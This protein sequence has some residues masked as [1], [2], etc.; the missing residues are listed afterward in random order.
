MGAYVNGVL[1][2]PV[3]AAS[4]DGVTANLGTPGAPQDGY[5]VTYEVNIND[6]VLVPMTVTAAR[7][8]DA[9][10]TG[11]DLVTATTPAEGRTV[12]SVSE[13][14]RLTE[15]FTVTD[16]TIVNATSPDKGSSAATFETGG[17]GRITLGTTGAAVGLT[18]PRIERALPAWD[19]NARWHFLVKLHARLNTSGYCNIDLYLRDS[20]G[21]A[22]RTI[23]VTATASP[24]DIYLTGNGGISVVGPAG[25]VAWDGASVIEIR[26]D[27]GKLSYGAVSGAGIF[28]PV[29]P[30]AAEALTFVPSHV[31]IT[32]QVGVA[33]AGYVE[34]IDP[35]IEVMQ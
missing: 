27:A 31:G 14:T 25:A 29:T 30:G 12:L 24:G 10:A 17:V 28:T 26:Y 18:G 23:E 6:L 35:I 9:G 5:V 11:I 3:D 34:G 7:I 16:W 20:A 4:L 32:G 15:A 8:T 21:T 1:V 22:Y 33:S 19:A 13:Y 2:P